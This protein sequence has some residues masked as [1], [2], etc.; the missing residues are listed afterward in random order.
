MMTTQILLSVITLIILTGDVVLVEA[1]AGSWLSWSWSQAQTAGKEAGSALYKGVREL[2]CLKIE[3][4]NPSWRPGNWTKL[5]E[6]LEDHLV[7]QHIARD[8]VV[9]AVRGHQTN[10]SPSKPL[11][12]SFH[13][14]TGSGK[15]F[16]SQFVAE[17]IFRQG[18]NS[19]YVHLFIATLHFPDARLT[20][21][22]KIQLRNWISGNVTSCKHNIFI[23]D[24]VD[25]MPPG[26]LD[27]VK[28]FMDYYE[29][30]D[31]VDYRRNI[32]L[33]LSNT[34]GKEITQTVFDSWNSGKDREK[35]SL[36]DLE[37]LIAAGAFNEAGGLQYSRMI[38]KNL[39]DVFVPFLPLERRH[40]KTCIRNE[41]NRRDVSDT[42][43][44]EMVDD[45]ADQLTY[46]PADL[47][48]FSTSGCKRVAQKV[49]LL[50]EDQEEANLNSDQ[51]KEEL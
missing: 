47:K 40:V 9:R 20:E 16:V 8:L 6:S 35:I 50:L 2:A 14:W 42:W 34:G 41:L 19:K 7:G 4:C 38:E 15:N 5:S 12:L 11:V 37:P 28:P 44:E 51:M 13:G 27:I 25:K 18:L 30:I 26:V 3:C 1:D 23:F 29:H 10:P 49:D 46:W 32:F 33:F 36:K 21:H 45:I 17:S 22:Y 24:E 31:G 48:L 39:V 43:T